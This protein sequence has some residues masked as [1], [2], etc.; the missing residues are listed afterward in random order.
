[1]CLH[2][3]GSEG[4]DVQSFFPIITKEAS[5]YDKQFQ[6]WNSEF[7]PHEIGQFPLVGNDNPYKNVFYDISSEN[8]VEK[9]VN[10]TLQNSKNTYIVPNTVHSTQPVS[11]FRK[12]DNQ[13]G[14]SVDDRSVSYEG[15]SVLTKEDK[16]RINV[17]S[18]NTLG[19]D[20]IHPILKTTTTT[21]PPVFYTHYKQGHDLI[22]SSVNDVSKNLISHEKF[23]KTKL[24][25]NRFNS[26]FLKHRRRNNPYFGKKKQRRRQRKRKRVKYLMHAKGRRHN[27][28][29]QVHPL[30]RQLNNNI[31]LSLGVSSPIDGNHLQNSPI[32]MKNAAKRT[33]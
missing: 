16:N 2:H 27:Q 10:E 1:M 31:G 9:N 32:M 4:T 13:P 17:I 5:Q 21:H 14:L 18:Q 23:R 19:N 24:K 28:N 15:W 25:R 29:H 30:A 12:T 11:N 3:Q 20:D 26:V 7:Q 8:S 22:N 33:D 6:H